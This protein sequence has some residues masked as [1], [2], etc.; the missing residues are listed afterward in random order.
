MENQE[1][2][3]L[4]LGSNSGD[5]ARMLISSIAKIQQKLGEIIQK[6]SIYKSKAWGFDGYDFLNQVV[7]VKTEKS[8]LECLKITQE[9]EIELGRL[10]KSKNRNYENRNIDI[11]ILFHDKRVFE[12][13]KL[14]IPHPRIQDRKFSLVPLNEIIPEFIHPQLNKSIRHLLDECT[15]Q[16]EVTKLNG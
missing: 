11:D 16:N 13:E 6:S 9:I 4:L 3:V 8:S 10:K 2:L 15:D 7:V 12:N 1:N 5:R 14:I